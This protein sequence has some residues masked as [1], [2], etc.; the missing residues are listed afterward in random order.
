MKVVL[1]YPPISNVRYPYLSLPC[2]SAFLKKAGH[3]PVSKDVNLEAF[4]HVMSWSEAGTGGGEMDPHVLREARYAVMN[5]KTEGEERERARSTLMRAY[6]TY[7]KGFEAETSGGSL[8]DTLRVAV[9]G[10]ND[11]FQDYYE[12][13]LIPWILEE[14][15]VLVG[16]S[17]AYPTQ[18]AHGFRIA[19]LIKRANPRVHLCM[20][21]PT[22]TKLMDH[23]AHR[24]ELLNA[25]D[26][27]I[28]H[29][30]EESLVRLVEAIGDGDSPE[31]IPNVAFK[32]GGRWQGNPL[33]FS[34]MDMNTLP[35]PDFEGFPLRFYLSKQ[36]TL[37]LITSRGCYWNRCTFCTYRELYKGAFQQRDAAL[38]VGDMAKLSREYGCNHFRLMDDACSPAFLRALART[39]IRSRLKVTWSCFARFEGAFTADFCRLLA[40][41]GCSR[42]MFGLESYNQRVLDLMNKGI[43]AE[44]IGSIVERC[45]EADIETRLM[46]MVGFP[47]ETRSEA[48]ATMQFL[49]DYRDKYTSFAAQ[50]FNLEGG[51]EIDC[52]P[53]RFGITEVH[54]G[55]RVQ[56]GLRYGYR[57]ETRSGM[58]M[59]EAAQMCEYITRKVR[60]VQSG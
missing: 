3:T 38:V 44:E 50:P 56:H 23:L 29:H 24:D 27:V 49:M 26:S 14:N 48:L 19:S 57:Y 5:P 46:C 33:C 7:Y 52:H 20:G 12:G 53:E 45:H 32:R 10:R 35:T 8:E 11:P 41:G 40:Q 60:R 6:L 1:I 17:I 9:E 28:L 4:Y 55:D 2:L 36:F 21:G 54:R 51:T 16:L 31:G 47:T 37:P 34:P 30:G 18:I 43:R 13:R 22:I 59:E 42:L 39:I 25:A 15:P 58:G